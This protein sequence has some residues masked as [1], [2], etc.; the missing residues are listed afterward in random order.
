MLLPVLVSDRLSYPN[1]GSTH[2]AVTSSST[3]KAVRRVFEAVMVLFVLDW[4]IQRHGCALGCFTPTLNWREE[5]G[6][7]LILAAGI[8]WYLL[9]YLF[10][11]KS[12]PATSS[13]S[14]INSHN[15]TPR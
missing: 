6:I 8:S 4:L 10:V 5:T 9:F 14:Q 11:S 13:T 3:N 12:H 7:I 1:D 2:A 15:D